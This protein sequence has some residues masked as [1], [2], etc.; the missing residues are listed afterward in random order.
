MSS[1]SEGTVTF[2][3]TDIEG[4]TRLWER[5]PDAMRLALACHDQIL[6]EA[7]E[8][9]NGHVFKTVGDAF[10][11]AF[12]TAQEALNAALEAHLALFRVEWGET[13]PI[14]VRMG[15]HTGE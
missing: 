3:F 15:L 1:L 13:G 4:S 14:R 10:Y 2:L 6:R 11:A 12:P 8:R 7:I 5:C 9:H